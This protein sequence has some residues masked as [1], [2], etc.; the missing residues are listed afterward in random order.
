MAVHSSNIERRRVPRFP[1]RQVVTLKVPELTGR[2]WGDEADFT[3]QTATCRDISA[4]GIFVWADTVVSQGTRVEVSM[5]APEEIL[6]HEEL[7]LLCTGTVLR[8][9]RGVL[10]DKVGLAIAFESIGTTE[11]PGRL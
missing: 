7:D 6:P 5:A 8:A 4:H 1:L 11:R 3:V 10:R 2:T 9:E